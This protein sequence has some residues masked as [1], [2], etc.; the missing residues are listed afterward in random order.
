M[1]TTKAPRKATA[2]RAA[3]KAP[4][5]ASPST[6]SNGAA[7]ELPLIPAEAGTGEAWLRK[8]EHRDGYRI[9]TFAGRRWHYYYCGAAANRVR[10]TGFR[11]YEEIFRIAPALMIAAERAAALKGGLPKNPDAGL[12]QSFLGAVPFDDLTLTAGKLFFT[13]VCM[14]YPSLTMDDILLD[15]DLSTMMDLVPL[16]AEQI[17]SAQQAIA[18]SGVDLSG[19]SGSSDGA[20]GNA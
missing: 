11:P 8:V 9:A 14:F 2:K 15:V 6:G 19:G 10:P 5:K 12:V 20:E 3:K 16:F 7:A 13:G 4:P 18:E 17:A 1:A